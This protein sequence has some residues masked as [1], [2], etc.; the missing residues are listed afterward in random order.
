LW[1]FASEWRQV[2]DERRC[3]MFALKPWMRETALLPRA[4]MPFGWMPE[5]FGK[6]FNRFFTTWPVMETPEWPFRWGL[7]AEEKEKEVVVRIELP[8]FEPGEVKVEVR[9][10]ELTIEAEHKEPSKKAEE[11]TEREYA[12]VK[13]VMTLPVGIEPEKAEALYRNGVL[14]VRIPRKP[15]AVGRRIEV[16]T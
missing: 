12:H 15:E 5:E 9:P 11:K 4:E 7:T 6:L 16:K 2:S 8:G 14:E 3:A 10:E 13:R 1:R